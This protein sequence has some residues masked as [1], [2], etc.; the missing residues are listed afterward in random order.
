[1][2][3]LHEAHPGIVRMKGLARSYCWW[4]GLDKSIEAKSKAC[5]YCQVNQRSPAGAPVHPW[6]TSGKPWARLHLD[7][8]GPFLGMMF[9]VIT[10]SFSKWMDVFPVKNATSLTTIERLRSSFSTHGV[11]EICVTDNGAAFTSNEFKRFMDKNAIR[12]VTSAPFHPSTN[13]RAERAVQT[14]KNAMKKMSPSSTESI[15][16]LVNR[17]L[18]RY[19][20][21]PHTSTNQS[22]AELLMGRRPA[23]ALD[24]LKPDYSRDDRLIQEKMIKSRDSKSYRNFAD[25]DTVWARNYGPG[26]KWKSA[27]VTRKTGPVSYEVVSDDIISR[28][29]VDQVRER[30]PSLDPTNPTEVSV[31]E[32]VTHNEVFVR[33]ETEATAVATPEA[34]RIDPIS[35]ADSSSDQPTNL[36]RERKRPEFLQVDPTKKT[37]N[38]K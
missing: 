13:G 21:T 2:E 8:A 31:T 9:L 3:E 34:S 23:S 29:H 28:K 1:M 6:E 12:H 24:R 5:H 11:P 10:D 20:I 4:P 36:R 22:P 7:Y 15:N 14:F 16:T 18:F 26:E 38:T 37:Y 35:D 27:K 19:R 17:F 33:N 25:G 30:Q 32:N